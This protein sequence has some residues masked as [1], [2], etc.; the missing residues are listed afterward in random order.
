[1]AAQITADRAKL[2]L[3]SSQDDY[4]GSNMLATM[5][6]INQWNE[7]AKRQDEHNTDP[8]PPPQAVFHL[9]AYTVQSYKQTIDD[10]R[11]KQ[12]SSLPLTKVEIKLDDGSKAT[13]ETLGFKRTEGSG[14][15]LYIPLISIG[16]D[17]SKEEERTTI[18]VD[19]SANEVTFNLIYRDLKTATI[20]PGAWDLGDVRKRY[21]QF[22]KYSPEKLT[23]LVRP[24]QLILATEVGLE[25]TF[26]GSLKHTFD[27]EVKKNTDAS[28]YLNLRIFNLDIAIG[29]KHETRDTKT[30]HEATWD[31]SSGSLSVKPSS[32]LGQITLLG[33]VGE[34][35]SF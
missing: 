24:T 8:I 18:K 15:L 1:L 6:D 28:G 35:L 4:P 3:A 26:T 23:E 30:T 2:Q 27:E 10:W 5:A 31:N 29:P 34:T 9:P 22:K 21:S 12:R 13:E 17:G 20:T 32:I 7:Y 14:S 19:E 16:A 11:A 25:V 33:V